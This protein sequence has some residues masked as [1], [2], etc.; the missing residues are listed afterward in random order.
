MASSRVAV[1]AGNFRNVAGVEALQRR[2]AQLPDV[3]F[4]TIRPALIAGADELVASIKQVTPLAPE[5]E[6]HPGD[7]RESVRRE[8]GDTELGVR[9]IEDGHDEHGAPYAAHVEYGHKTPGGGHVAAKP[10]FWP[11]YQ[12]GKRRFVSRVSR[13]VTEALRGFR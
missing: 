10:H 4:D 11:A 3:I 9:I 2:M 1:F 5:F 13:S 7:L 8:D 6:L 12:V